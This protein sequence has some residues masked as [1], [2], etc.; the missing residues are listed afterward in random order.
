[1]TTKEIA[2]RIRAELIKAL[3]EK[4]ETQNIKYIQNHPEAYNYDPDFS[5][6]FH[7]ESGLWD[8]IR[9]EVKV[10]SKSSLKNLVSITR[11]FNKE[12]IN[13]FESNL[14]DN[15]F[16]EL[17]DLSCIDYGVNQILVPFKRYT[18]K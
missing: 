3:F 7:F 11:K 12:F 10:D 17:D 8:V 9:I 13:P 1:M 15:F 16:I 14:K 4:L 18:L 6:E 2:K 5:T